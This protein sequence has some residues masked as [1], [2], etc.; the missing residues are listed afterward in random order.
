MTRASSVSQPADT[1][2][3]RGSRRNLF[4]SW[5]VWRLVA[6][7]SAAIFMCVNGTASSL[8]T[9][10][11]RR[12][13]KE[14]SPATPRHSTA[15]ASDVRNAYLGG[16][17]FTN[18]PLPRLVGPSSVRTS[19]ARRNKMQPA[20]PTAE[21][22]SRAQEQTP[23]RNPQVN[24]AHPLCTIA[25]FDVSKTLHSSRAALRWCDESNAGSLRG[26]RTRARGLSL[27]VARLHPAARARKDD[28]VSEVIRCQLRFSGVQGHAN[29]VW[30]SYG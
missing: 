17:M 19:E 23:S 12:N 29:N 13:G 9:L 20:A 5:R 14:P 11:D 8:W 15:M 3:H 4:N 25:R 30:N 24:A 10:P 6:R 1:P 18:A 26:G 27:D 28:H 7:P 22:P 16:G 21:A 2:A